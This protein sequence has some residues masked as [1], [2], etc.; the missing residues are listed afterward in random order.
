M[1]AEIDSDRCQGH[2][3]CAVVCPEV[4]DLDEAGAGVVILADV[5]ADLRDRVQ[6][7]ELNCPEQAIT[8]T[9]GELP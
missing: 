9:K 3:R 6:M 8:L 2:G 4:F 1:R 7:A 5:P